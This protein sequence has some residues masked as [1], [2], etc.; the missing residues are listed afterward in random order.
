MKSSMS[1]GRVSECASPTRRSM[2]PTSGSGGGSRLSWRRYV[3][4][5]T[6]VDIVSFSITS[7]MTAV[8]VQPL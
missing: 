8:L 1:S 3:T 4:T 5:V 7:T 2:S 6:I